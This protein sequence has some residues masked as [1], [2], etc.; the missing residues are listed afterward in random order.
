[1]TINQHFQIRPLPP[2]RVRV[3]LLGLLL[4]FLLLSTLS[5]GQAKFQF[6]RPRK[7]VVIPFEFHRN[8][9][10]LPVF[11]NQKG[12]FNFMLDTGISLSLII[13]PA[14]RDSLQITEGR[15]VKVVGAGE[16]GGLEAL[17]SS[18]FEMKF[19]GVTAKNLTMAVLSEDVL[20]LSNYVGLPVHGILGYDLFSSFVVDINYSASSLTLYQ[21]E[22][23]KPRRRDKP[24]PISLEFQKPYVNAQGE[25]NDSTSLPLKLVIDT[26]AGHGLSLE[27]G[28]HPAIQIPA[29]SLEAQ[30]GRGLGGAINGSIGRI[31]SL[32]LDSYLLQNIIT[33]FPDHDDVGAK[34]EQVDRNG[35]IGNEI[36]KR[37]RAIFDYQRRQLILRPNRLYRQPFEHDMVGVHL[38]AEGSELRRYIIY[39]VEAGS[40]A[41]DA[42]LLPED[43]IVSINLVPVST[44]PITRI[45]Q[46]FR[47]KD[48]QVL[49]VQINRKGQSFYTFITLRRQI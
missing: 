33:S 8:L 17:I 44:M 2:F 26:G 16:E 29:I 10:I 48:K 36:L 30:L 39:R 6:D 34:L 47:S 18:G 46:L 14:L 32:Q 42:G 40:P 5:Q 4:F 25:L 15:T 49:F 3:T 31:K 23:Y 21:P 35:N 27:T 20:F 45:D 12:P 11:L 37:F 38:V 28:S 43:E 19:A 13:D 1:M 7:R 24:I 22:A 9:I 41:E